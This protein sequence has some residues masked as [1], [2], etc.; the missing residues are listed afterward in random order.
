MKLSVKMPRK[1]GT[2]THVQL[3][4][5]E[6][7]VKYNLRAVHKKCSSTKPPSYVHGSFLNALDC[8][9]SKFR[10]REKYRVCENVLRLLQAKHGDNLKYKRATMAS[11]SECE[12]H[13]GGD[14]E[15]SSGQSA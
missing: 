2:L 14:V 8:A 13:T 6:K 1:A 15:P 10:A 4:R 11:V 7:C 3:L 12:E 9:G 5:C